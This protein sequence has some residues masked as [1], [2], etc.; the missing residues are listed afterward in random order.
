MKPAIGARLGS[1]KLVKS[2]GAGASAYVYL[3]EHVYI[4]TQAAIKVLD[5]G[6]G[7]AQEELELFKNEA[8]TIARLPH[9]NIVRI[10]EFGIE[11]NLAYLVM[12]YAA[13][14]SVRAKYPKGSIVRPP[15]I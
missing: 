3:G 9:P 12:E 1:Y 11:G 6:S 10:L 13:H 8:R 2:L 5:F 7:I 4:K 14:G 15:D